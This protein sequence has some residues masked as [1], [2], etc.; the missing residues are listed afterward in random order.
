MRILFLVL[1]LA[2]CGLAAWYF[3]FNTPDFPTRP[4][5]TGAP[6][7]ELFAGAGGGSAT[8]SAASGEAPANAAPA[9]DSNL[10]SCISVGPFPNRV[11]IEDAV[12]AL[13]DR[14]FVTSQ[15][16]AQGDVWLGYWVYIDAI[17]T[18]SEAAAIVEQLG[19]EGMSEAYVIA[20]GNNGSI[21]SLGV[22]SEQ[23]RAQQRFADVEALGLAAVVANRS[24]PGEVFWLDVTASDGRAFE[25][26]ELPEIEVDPEPQFV[27]CVESDQ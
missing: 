5:R 9:D 20:D 25:V 16:N 17:A 18:Q 3:W 24:Q 15:R 6:N 2:N 27:D 22:F 11:D 4:L 21:V 14:G 1:V 26:T 7:I 8:E 19:R 10:R 12:A 23:A 13:R